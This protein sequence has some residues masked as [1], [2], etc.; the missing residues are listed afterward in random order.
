MDV[1]RISRCRRDL[2][3]REV[4][5]G[6]ACLCSVS[7]SVTPAHSAFV[8]VLNGDL[9]ATASGTRISV[10]V[11]ASGSAHLSLLM[12]DCDKEDLRDS[13]EWWAVPYA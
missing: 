1:L 7:S 10:S 13:T 6:S 12:P 9:F 4:G 11:S 3:G 8:C 2:R 5:L